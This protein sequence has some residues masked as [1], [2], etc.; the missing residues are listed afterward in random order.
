MGADYMQF[1]YMLLK[2]IGRAGL[3]YMWLNPFLSPSTPPPTTPPPP[4]QTPY[5]KLKNFTWDMLFFEQINEL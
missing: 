1:T 4:P 3:I 2:L 5:K